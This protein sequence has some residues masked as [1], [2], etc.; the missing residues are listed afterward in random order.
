MAMTTGGSSATLGV[1]VVNA[2]SQGLGRP[3]DHAA[4]QSD[5]L[6]IWLRTSR[7]AARLVATWVSTQG[8]PVPAPASRA[9]DPS[10]AAPG[11][12]A[13]VG[14]RARPRRPVSTCCCWTS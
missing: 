10:A 3:V 5:S 12:T 11:G 2:G 7:T 14:A 4:G 6:L 1:R 13:A 9:L 8:L